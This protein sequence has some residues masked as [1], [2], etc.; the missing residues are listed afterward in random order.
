MSEA[1]QYKYDR[2]GADAFAEFRTAKTGTTF[3][4]GDI[5]AYSSSA[6]TVEL[7]TAG[8]TRIAGIAIDG[9]T[10]AVAGQQVQVQINPGAVY[11]VKYT[12]GTKTS[13]AGSDVGTSFDL[14]SGSK[15]INLDD[16]TGGMCKVV[17]YDNTEKT[18]DVMIGSR[19]V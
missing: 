19:L 11:R 16:T 13:L 15:T 10:N 3:A 1:F 17:A 8:S 7:A 18:A 14:A 5:L 9:V 6:D 12:P 4:A 2:Y